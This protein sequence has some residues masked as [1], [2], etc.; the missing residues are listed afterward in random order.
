MLSTEVASAVARFCDR[1]GP[2]GDELTRIFQ[3]HGLASGDP[4]RAPGGQL[5][6][7]MKRVRQVLFYAL[8]NDSE[9]GDR[10]LGDLVGVI[11]ASGG[12]R[13]GSDQYPGD[14][15]VQALREAFADQGY[16]LAPDGALHPTVLD[17]MDGRDLT[18][19]LRAYVRRARAG[20]MDAALGVGNAKDFLEA[21]ARH[22][23]KQ[24]SPGGYDERMNFS[25]T[26][27][28]AFDQLGL[29]APRTDVLDLIEKD[30]QRAV[31]QALYMLGC[32]VNRLRNAEGTGHGRPFP[33]SVTDDEAAIAVQGMG[34]VVQ[35]LLDVLDRR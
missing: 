12:F 1:V 15:A 30:P 31:D 14:E 2:S 35:R 25:G 19:A 5:T 27:W 16:T 24:T 13:P 34:V 29:A 18:D 8:D 6:G 4:A 17:N 32:A 20:T 9:A 7:K 33:A 23:L 26:L 28:N 11:R 3:R 21:T 22:V 10:L